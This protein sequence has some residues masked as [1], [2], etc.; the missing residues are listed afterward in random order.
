[1]NRQVWAEMNKQ[2]RMTKGQFWSCR[3]AS[4]DIR[5]FLALNQNVKTYNQACKT[6]VI[7]IETLKVKYAENKLIEAKSI[8]KI[9]SLEK[10]FQ[11]ICDMIFTVFYRKNCLEKSFLQD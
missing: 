8:Y 9:Y 2:T 10:S 6:W 3:E 5:F 1:M 11:D 4:N 7:H